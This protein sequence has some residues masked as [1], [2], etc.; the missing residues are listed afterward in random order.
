MNAEPRRR[1]A[2]VTCMDARLDVL[3]GFALD[4]GDAHVLRNAGGL[5]T[6]DMLRSLAISQ[7][8]LG[9]TEVAVMHHTNCGMEGF[10]DVEFRLGLTEETDVAPTWDVPGFIDLEHQVRRSVETVRACP[11]L[12]HRDAVRG[13]VYDVATASVAEVEATI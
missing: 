5:I 6:D 3:T 12:P 13:Y 2:I 8:A 11:W 4:L 7:R 10:D 1:L 9:T